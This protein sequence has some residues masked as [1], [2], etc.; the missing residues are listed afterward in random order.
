[1]PT[2]AATSRL[3]TPVLTKIKSYLFPWKYNTTGSWTFH[4][5]LLTLINM[6]LKETN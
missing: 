2:A 3:L 1:M 6:F 5:I 4:F